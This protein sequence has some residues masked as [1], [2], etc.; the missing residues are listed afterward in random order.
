M[1]RAAVVLADEC[2]WVEG[3][4]CW[5]CDVDTLLRVD[6]WDETKRV[7]YISR[8]GMMTSMLTLGFRGC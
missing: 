6:S 4:Y 8:N 1:Y 7:R 2:V 5:D 3:G